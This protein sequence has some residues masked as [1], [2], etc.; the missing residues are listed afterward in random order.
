VHQFMR[1]FLASSLLCGIGMLVTAHR[2]LAGTPCDGS[3]PESRS[4]CVDAPRIDFGDLVGGQAA[5]ATVVVANLTSTDRPF[6]GLVLRGPDAFDIV[7]TDCILANGRRGVGAT[8]S[9]EITIAFASSSIEPAER[10]ASTLLITSLTNPGTSC[11]SAS[12]CLA[13]VE[14]VG[15][16]AS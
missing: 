4:I 14:L 15:R 7:R 12:D 2:S 5:T 11:R 6:G 3:S 10:V 13:T 16:R 1:V 8:G 9:C